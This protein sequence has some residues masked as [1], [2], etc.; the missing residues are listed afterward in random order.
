MRRN[1]IQSPCWGLGHRWKQSPCSGLAL[2]FAAQAEWCSKEASMRVVTFW[3]NRDA[4]LPYGPLSSLDCI[5][6][7]GLAGAWQ[8]SVREWDENERKGFVSKCCPCHFRQQD[9]QSK[10]S[11][12]GFETAR[13]NRLTIFSSPFMDTDANIC[14]AV[15]PHKYM[16]SSLWWAVCVTDLLCWWNE[17][18]RLSLLFIHTS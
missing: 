15:F 5:R 11:L 4:L 8:A 16:H 14:R 3:Q 1:S 2:N 9:V 17:N 18:R 7:S 13:P 10:Y 12:Q 6:A